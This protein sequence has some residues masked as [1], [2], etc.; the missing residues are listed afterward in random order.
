MPRRCLVRGVN[1]P[2]G[3][4]S[5]SEC[6]DWV[7]GLVGWLGVDRLPISVFICVDVDVR[8]YMCVCVCI[9]VCVC[10]CV[11]VLIMCNNVIVCR[12]YYDHY[13]HVCVS[14]VYYEHV[15]VS[16][17]YYVVINLPRPGRPCVALLATPTLLL[18]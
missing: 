12:V 2:E 4:G 17:V 9:C 8:L 5:S 10:V 11:C 14:R 13:D 18:P 16:L 6:V 15:C 3:M 7:V 1:Q